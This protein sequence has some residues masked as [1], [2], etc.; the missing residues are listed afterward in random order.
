MRKLA[1]LLV[2]LAIQSP[3]LF[4]IIP[5]PLTSREEESRI[6][7]HQRDSALLP[8][9]SLIA[10][11]ERSHLKRLHSQRASLFVSDPYTKYLKRRATFTVLPQR[12][13]LLHLNNEKPG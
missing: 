12:S 5:G 9:L 7:I 8:G 10:P 1:G 6:L 13:H 3:S 11:A 2:F 4:E